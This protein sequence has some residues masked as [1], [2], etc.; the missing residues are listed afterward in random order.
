MTRLE[1]PF[2]IDGDLIIVRAL[3]T[4]PRGTVPGSFVLDTGA[5]ATTMIPEFAESIG[6]SA[7]D[8]FK[9]TR[10][11]TAIGDEEGYAVHAVEFAVLGVAMPGFPVNVFDL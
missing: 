5:V 7:R 2:D 6:Y 10:V 11:R 9:R 8:A 1:T 4:G 3:V